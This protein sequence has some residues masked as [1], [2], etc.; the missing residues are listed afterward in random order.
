LQSRLQEWTWEL[1]GIVLALQSA[2]FSEDALVL[3][4]SISAII[5]V[6]TLGP[7]TAKSIT[8]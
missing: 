3:C 7:L 5:A 2:A 4:D 1:G 8:T 6:Q